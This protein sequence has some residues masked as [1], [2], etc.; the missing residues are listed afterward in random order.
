MKDTSPLSPSAA[1]ATGPI[2]RAFQERTASRGRWGWLAVPVIGM[3]LWW[4]AHQELTPPARAH[5]PVRGI[6][7]VKSGMTPDEVSGLLGR[8]FGQRTSDDGRA[9]CFQYGRPTMEKATFP[10]YSLCYEGGKLRE[11][12]VKQYTA[13]PLTPDGLPQL[14][15]DAAPPA[16][17]ANATKPTP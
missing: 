17:A 3:G 4:L 6:Q 11:M 12:T 8:P 9:E 7:A 5:G 2:F 16:P 15:G 14:P 10:V 13:L 1:P